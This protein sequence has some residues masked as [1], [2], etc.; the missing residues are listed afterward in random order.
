MGLAFSH[1]VGH[2]MNIDNGEHSIDV[3]VL[4]IEG[5]KRNKIATLAIQDSEKE[6]PFPIVLSYAD[7]YPYELGHDIE[8]NVANKKLGPKYVQ[9]HYSAPQEYKF[10][11]ILVNSML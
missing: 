1:K 9:L 4:R 11:R 8:I 3:I 5:K 7:D 10:T 6:A 2:G